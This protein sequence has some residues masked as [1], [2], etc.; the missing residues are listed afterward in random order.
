M[1]SILIP[2]Y[3]HD[4]YA[5]VEQLHRQCTDT[6]ITFEII[7]GDD[8]STTPL[9]N[10]QQIVST[11]SHAQIIRPSHNLGRSAIRNFLAIH[12]HYENLLFID[13]DSLPAND[14]YIKNYLPHLGKIVLGGRSYRKTNTPDNSLLTKYG[15]KNERNRNITPL[16][17]TAPFT[18]PNF[19][20]PRSILLQI[21]FNEKIKEYGHEDTILGIELIRHNFTYYRFDNPVI[22]THI[23]DNG[24]FIAKTK[25]AISHLL[26]L[27]NSGQYHELTQTSP[28]LRTYLKFK[29]MRLNNILSHIYAH[30]GDKIAK[31]LDTPNPN[32][33]RFAQFKLLYIAHIDQQHCQYDK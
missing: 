22:H 8:C 27:H 12:A 16:P 4:C 31:Q 28:L 1:L 21:P 14:N 18:S 5:L 32:L 29:K 24:E 15:T 7:V 25:L 13:A 3:N 6:Q 10:T 17:S 30:Y 23:E 2:S 20:I 19:T 33:R 9:I 26:Q 11:L